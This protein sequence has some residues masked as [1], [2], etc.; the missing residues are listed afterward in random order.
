MGDRFEAVYLTENDG[1]V[2]AEVKTLTTDDLPEGD[3]MVEISHSTINYKDGMII[4]GLGRLVRDYPHVPGIDFSAR[5]SGPPMIFPSRA[6]R[7][8]SRVGASAKFWGGLAGRAF[9]VRANWPTPLPVS[10]SEREAMAVGTAGFT[11]MLCVL[12]L[13]NTAYRPRAAPFW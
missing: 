3:V 12:G 6:T 11:A 7:W 4:K 2:S 8:S 5:F 9:R 13:E 10:L 1:K